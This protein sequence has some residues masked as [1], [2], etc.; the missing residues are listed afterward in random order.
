MKIQHVDELHCRLILKHKMCQKHCF[1]FV[2]PQTLDKS[3]VK[4]CA[5]SGY[6][7]VSIYFILFSNFR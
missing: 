4:L 1:D 6:S 2:F 3:T 7:S 5:Q